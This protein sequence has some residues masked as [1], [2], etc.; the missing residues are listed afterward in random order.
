MLGLQEVNLE[1]SINPIIN[2]KF[3]LI[4]FNCQKNTIRKKV[5][6]VYVFL[7]SFLRF[8]I[9]GYVH[10]FVLYNGSYLDEN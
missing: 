7:R 3:G 10:I 6:H 9:K 5:M 2:N 4:E 8:N 1:I